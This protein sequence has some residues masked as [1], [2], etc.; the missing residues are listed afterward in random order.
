MIAG[1]DIGTN[2]VACFI[3]QN[4]GQAGP[5]VTGSGQYASAGMRSGEVINLES[6]RDA[7]GEAVGA[8]ERMSGLEIERLAVSVSGGVQKSTLQ[9]D[10]I[11]TADGH[12]SERDIARL[13]K[14]ALEKEVSPER[15]VLHR[16]PLQFTLDGIRGIKDPIGMQGRK[17][18]VDM[19]VITAAKSTLENIRTIV[20]MNHLQVECFVS[21]AYAAGLTALVED[22]K[23]LGA[24]IIEMGAGVTSIAIFM[25]GHLVLC[26]LGATRRGACDIRY[27]AHCFNTD[28]RS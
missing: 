24:T 28:G 4:D 7:V 25:E 22:E 3:A 2:K 11:D 1:L 14:K 16:L 13:L 15:T 8:A 27:R 26:Q 19:A 17:L 20:E 18:G 10:E 23:D 9:K 6:L 21:S 12:V 5:I